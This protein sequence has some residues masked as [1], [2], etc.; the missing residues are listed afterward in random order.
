MF[1]ITYSHNLLIISAGE[2]QQHFVRNAFNVLVNEGFFRDQ[3]GIQSLEVVQKFHQISKLQPIKAKMVEKDLIDYS[4]CGQH[5]LLYHAVITL[6]KEDSRTKTKT[7][8][9]VRVSK[10]FISAPNFV[11]LT[12]LI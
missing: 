4:Y 7:C 2:E 12:S 6:V 10:S 9:A 1:R 5:C 8:H 3:Q 11:C